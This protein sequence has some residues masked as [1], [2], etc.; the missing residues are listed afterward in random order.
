[1][2][3]LKTWIIG[4]DKDEEDGEK[5]EWNQTAFTA[6]PAVKVKGLAFSMEKM[7][8]MRFVDEPKMRIAAPMV[9]P[10]TIYRKGDEK[11][12]EEDYEVEFTVDEIEKMLLKLMS[13]P[14]SLQNFFNVEHTD[15]QVPAFVFQIWIVDDSQTDKSYTTY[16]VKVPK[17]SIFAVAQ[18]TDK[19]YFDQLVA[20]D[21][22]GFSVQGIFNMTLKNEQKTNEQQLSVDINAKKDE[23][24]KLPDGEYTQDGKVFVVKNGEF[25]EKPA[26]DAAATDEQKKKEADDLAKKAEMD[27]ETPAAGNENADTPTPPSD[28]GDGEVEDKPLTKDDVV[29][30]IKDEVKPMIDAAMK[31]VVDQVV[32]ADDSD[33]AA[34]AANSGEDKGQSQSFSNQKSDKMQG[35]FSVGKF[36]NKNN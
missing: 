12:G 18:I 19:D 8:Q 22:T 13:S 30:L 2:S 14:G 1:M 29:N 31:A 3:E 9:I 15:E 33:D 24:M 32:K 17:G 4:T 25:S 36:L 23:E 10:M 34:A 11:E 35:A 28:N 6:N 20:N 5:I 21:Q 16:G 26:D 27:A 7:K